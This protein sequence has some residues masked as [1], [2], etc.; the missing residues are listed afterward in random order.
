[1][2]VLA[3]LREKGIAAEIYPESAKL[4][5]TIYLRRKERHRKPYF[6]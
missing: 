1:M 3:K 4:K 5:K 2:K 6:P